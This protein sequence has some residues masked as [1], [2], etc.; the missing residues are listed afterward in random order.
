LAIA[1]AS[2]VNLLNLDMIIVGGPMEQAGESLLGPLRSELRRR[3]LPTHLARLEVVPSTLKED[4]PSIGA[5]S[6]VLHELM[7]PA[8][9]P[10]LLPN[11]AN[12]AG[13]FGLAN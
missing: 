5:A 13:L 3:A 7:S 6:L 11:F 1:L 2:A 4:A 8:P 9:L 12:K 10:V